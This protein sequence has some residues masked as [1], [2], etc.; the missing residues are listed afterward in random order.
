MRLLYLMI[1]LD[2]G[3]FA[4]IN[5]L[6]T[7][8]PIHF[9]GHRYNILL[10]AGIKVKYEISTQFLSI[11]TKSIDTSVLETV[12]WFASNRYSNNHARE[13]CNWRKMILFLFV[14]DRTYFWSWKMGSKYARTKEFTINLKTDFK[15]F[16]I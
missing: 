11:R 2:V 1:L 16:L 9:F 3:D 5:T 10:K 4:W 14:E 8:K 6:S 13:C 12:R 7:R 15:V